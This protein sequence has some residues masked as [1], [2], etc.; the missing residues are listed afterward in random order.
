MS[1]FVV[2]ASTGKATIVKDPN[3]IKE[4]TEDWTAFL[5]PVADTIVSAEFIYEAVPSMTIDPAH[6]VS[7]ISVDGMKVTGWFLGPD[8]G[9]TEGVTYRITTAAGR[10]DDKT[11]YFKGKSL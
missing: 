4:Y 9:R 10:K 7:A 1:E 11:L 8:D 6:P 5:T 2:N 3:S